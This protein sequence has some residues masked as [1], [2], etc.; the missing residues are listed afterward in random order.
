[1][2]NLMK[3]EKE[4]ASES[5]K[6]VYSNY[7][8]YLEVLLLTIKRDYEQAKTK[9]TEIISNDTSNFLLMNNIAV[10]DVYRNEPKE[11]YKNLSIIAEQM[12]CC[13]QPLKTNSEILNSMFNMKKIKI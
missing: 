13:S 12:D 3:E 2:L 4:K 9:L 7:I 6:E 5:L 1:M 10:L 8:N 11:S